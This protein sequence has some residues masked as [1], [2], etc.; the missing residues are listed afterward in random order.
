MAGHEVAV[1]ITYQIAKAIQSGVKR[2]NAECEDT[3]VYV[4]LILLKS[5]L[6]FYNGRSKYWTNNDR[7][8]GK[9]TL[10]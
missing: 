6:L 1:I 8:S 7:H 9:C 2:V 10:T 3:D 5:Q 4:L